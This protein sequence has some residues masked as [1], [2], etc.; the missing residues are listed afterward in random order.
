[1]WRAVSAG[2]LVHRAD[3]LIACLFLLASCTTVLV[4]IYYRATTGLRMLERKF[5]PTQSITNSL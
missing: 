4:G 5:A 2:Q 3:L 1:L